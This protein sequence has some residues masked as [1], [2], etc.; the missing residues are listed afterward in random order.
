MRADLAQEIMS[1]SEEWLKTRPAKPE[2]EEDDSDGEIAILSQ[3]PVPKGKPAASQ[4][5]KELLKPKV[6]L[7]P[8]VSQK[9]KTSHK[10]DVSD[11]KQDTAASASMGPASRLR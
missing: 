4:K 5:S 1:R 6:T 7:K 8:E 11:S 9:P 10:P 3:N 2:K